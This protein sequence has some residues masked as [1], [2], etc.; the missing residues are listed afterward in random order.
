M[1]NNAPECTCFY[2]STSSAPNL[3]PNSYLNLILTVE[4][5]LTVAVPVVH[6]GWQTSCSY[7]A[8]LGSPFAY[9]NASSCFA[10]LRDVCLRDVCLRDVCLRDACLRDACLRDACS[11]DACLRYASAWWLFAFSLFAW[12]LFALCLFAFCLFVWCLFPWCLLGFCLLAFFALLNYGYLRNRLVTRLLRIDTFL[13]SIILFQLLSIEFFN[14]NNN[15]NNNI[16]F[17]VRKY[18]KIF[19][20]EIIKDKISTRK[21]PS[22]RW[23]LNPRPSVT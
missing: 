13:I 10:C 3:N 17:I 9:R 5:Y 6:R 22:S 16:F 8:R 12:C 11:R 2:M 14:T 21:N 20:K 1:L 7:F 19:F 15:N 4:R 23:D 18:S